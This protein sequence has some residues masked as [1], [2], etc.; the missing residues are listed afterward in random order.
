[1]YTLLTIFVFL[2]LVINVSIVLH[3]QVLY[4]SLKQLLE[5]SEPD[6][7]EVFMQTFRIS[8]QDVFGSTITY[9]L[10]ENGDQLS[11][12]QENKYVSCKCCSC[13]QEFIGFSFRN[14]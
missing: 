3:L 7:D 5:Y 14:L 6:L 12:T 4:N 8:Y 13:S 10:K 1:M 11:V 9:D 2:K